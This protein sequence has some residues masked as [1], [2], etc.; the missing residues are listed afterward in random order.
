MKFD[1]EFRYNRVPWRRMQA[2]L[3]NKNLL[4]GW[5][6][7]YISDQV[8]KLLKDAP[9][10]E[11]RLKNFFSDWKPF[12]KLV[13]SNPE[14]K[15]AVSLILGD[16]F[17]PF[18]FL[19]FGPPG[20]GKTVTLVEAIKQ[21]AL[22]PTS[23]ILICAPS[24]SAADL[25]L[26]R[27]HDNFSPSQMF[28]INAQSRK[29]PS[30]FAHFDKYVMKNTDGD[31]LIPPLETIIKF[32]IIISTCG[33]AA[34]FHGLGVKPGHFTHIFIDE[35]GQAL[36]PEAMIPLNLIA[37]PSNTRFVLAGDHKQLGPIIHSSVSRKLGLGVSLLER[38]M[39]YIDLSKASYPLRIKNF[40]NPRNQKKSGNNEK[41]MAYDLIFV[42]LLQNYRSHP[43]LLEV[44]N[45]LFYGGSLKACA[46]EMITKQYTGWQ[47]LPDP[48]HPMLFIHTVGKDERD[49][50]SPSFFNIAEIQEV[51]NVVESLREDRSGFRAVTSDKIG[52]ITPYNKQRSN[53]ERALNAKGYPG[54][55]VGTVEAFQ[56]QER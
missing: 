11:M 51:L 18:P 47:Q 26:E 7:M 4:T 21:V 41:E 2:A 32:K 46:D 55:N 52:V 40:H 5:D 17:L 1:V 34:V 12:N 53:L 10:I 27:L 25:F 54:I 22:K 35:C 30:H 49:G 24:N 37:H 19:L 50:S 6:E 31:Y 29:Q 20:T 14:Q 48:N 3:E 16:S 9:A 13:Y 56:G 33:T 8:Q 45:S 28:R 43:S 44:P 36:E 15:R 23:R 39:G 38:L 42:K